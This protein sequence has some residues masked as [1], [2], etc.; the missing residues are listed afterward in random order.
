VLNIKDKKEA[1]EKEARGNNA[2][3]QEEE[4]PAVT[5]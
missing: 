2:G 4:E 1:E 3:T 5:T